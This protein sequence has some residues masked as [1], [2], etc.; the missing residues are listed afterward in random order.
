[1]RYTYACIALAG[2]IY[3]TASIRFEYQKEL[4]QE[5]VKLNVDLRFVS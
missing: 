1:M 5:V 3:L 2:N 4:L